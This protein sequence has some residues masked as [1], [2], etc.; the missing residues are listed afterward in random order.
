MS[1]ALRCSQRVGGRA[2][3]QRWVRRERVNRRVGTVIEMTVP[4]LFYDVEVLVA[5]LKA[6]SAWSAPTLEPVRLRT[7]DGRSPHVGEFSLEV[8][9]WLPADVDADMA[10]AV[11]LAAGVAARGALMA[12]PRG[13][14]SVGS[15]A[16]DQAL[17]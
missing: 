15:F 16:S 5:S 3:L 2:A 13:S 17:F 4:T 8:Y 14:I 1:I 12:L 6:G 10:V 9:G 7:A 11:G